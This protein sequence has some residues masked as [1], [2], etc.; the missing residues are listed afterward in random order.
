MSAVVAGLPSREPEK[1]R[2]PIISG[3]ASNATGLEIAPNC[4][5]ATLWGKG[6]D[7]RHPLQR[8]GN[9]ADDEIKSPRLRFQSFAIAGVDDATGTKLHKFIRFIGRGGKGI[10]NELADD[11]ALTGSDKV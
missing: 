6:C 2:C 8:N 10:L 1:E 7:I 5:Q 3:N 9:G 11:S 4:V